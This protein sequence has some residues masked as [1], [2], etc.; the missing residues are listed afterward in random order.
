MCNA[1]RQYIL[2]FLT[3][4]L[5]LTAMCQETKLITK[6]NNGSKQISE[7]YYVLKSDG[8]TKHGEYVSY[9]SVTKDKNKQLK[10]GTLKLE[11]YIKQK[12]SYKN[13]KKDG[14]WVEY[15]RPNEIKAKGNYDNDKKAGIWLTSKEKGEVFVRFDYDSNKKLPPIFFMN[16]K[17]PR[18]AFES[19]LEGTVIVTFQTYTDCSIS[20]ITVTKSLSVDCDKAAIESIK[21][22]GELLKN[23]GVDCEEKTETQEIKFVLN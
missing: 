14:E 8:Q 20:N 10:K 4:L 22:F 6:K 1:M 23:Y 7:S 2:T 3:L 21:E 19:G 11:N 9:F 17:Y 18:S 12:G 13:G 16:V 15:S 5:T